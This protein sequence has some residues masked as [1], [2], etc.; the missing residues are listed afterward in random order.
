[1][2]D[3][4]VRRAYTSYGI[5][6]IVEID[7]VK[8]T[9]SLVKKDGQPKSFKFAERTPEYFNGWRAI[10]LAQE[11]A[12]SEVQKEFAKLKDKELKEFIELYQSLDNSLK[13]GEGDLSGKPGKD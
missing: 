7:F 2:K 3:L 4:F 10:M 13:K 8:K 9:A 11:Y 1:M 6:I 12:V 5:T